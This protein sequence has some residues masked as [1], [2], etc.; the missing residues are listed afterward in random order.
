MLS[1]M[2][3]LIIL[4]SPGAGQFEL[5]AILGEPTGIS[6]KYWFGP[7][8]AFDGAVSWSLRDDDEDLYIHGDFLW[9]DFTLISDESG[10][11][12][13]YFGIGG[14]VVLA[15]DT[16]LGARV[17]AGI[18]WI[19]GGGPIDVFIEAAGV[20]DIVPDTDFELNGG[21]GVRFMF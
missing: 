7:E 20:V 14:R 19:I 4:A 15:T 3:S 17:P 2:I 21:L 1:T 5:G 10:L 13:V 16:K 8:T 18:S 12:P 6:G 9:H 11:L